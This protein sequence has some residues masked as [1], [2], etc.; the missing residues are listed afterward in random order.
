MID[1]TKI[2][3]EE[4]AIIESVLLTLEQDVIRKIKEYKNTQLMWIIAGLLREVKELEDWWS[5][6]YK[7]IYQ[8]NI[9]E[10]KR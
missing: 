6:A 7:L 2:T 9:E 10:E 5:E 1:L 3:P 4:A 8:K